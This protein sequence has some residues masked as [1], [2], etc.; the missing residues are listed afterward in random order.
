MVIC[1]TDSLDVR[2][3]FFLYLPAGVEG[4]G[5]A[6]SLTIGEALIL[7]TVLEPDWR[8]SG[9]NILDMI[10]HRTS[11]HRHVLY[12]DVL[13]TRTPY[14]RG[15]QEASDIRKPPIFCFDSINNQEA[16]SANIVLVNQKLC[17]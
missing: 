3:C 17:R 1:T 8:N 4:L 10:G 15:N 14:F 2:I 6:L 11:V 12:S 13:F 5:G 7:G 16:K 9:I